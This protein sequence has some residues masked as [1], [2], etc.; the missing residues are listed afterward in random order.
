VPGHS[1]KCLVDKGNNMNTGFKNYKYALEYDLDQIID[2]EFILNALKAAWLETPSKNNFMPYKVHVLGPEFAKEKDELYW[3]CLGNETKANNEQITDRNL[4]KMYEEKMY[5]GSAMPNYFNIVNS[6]YVLI[7]TQRIENKLNEHQ[8]S[9]VKKGY[10]YE[11]MAKDGPKREN[12]RKNAYLEIGMFST[13]FA[14]ICLENGIDVSHT[15]CFPGDK[16]DWPQEHFSFLDSHPMLIM[17]VG[18]GKV[19]RTASD[20]AIDPKPDFNRIV[21]IVRK[22]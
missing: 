2:P 9:L 19:Y 6:S 8:Q 22:M 17:T 11:Q 3:L 16:K 7:F 10:V 4:L 14:G 1:K 20:H 18:K 5:P 12:A 13:N 15:L 21:N